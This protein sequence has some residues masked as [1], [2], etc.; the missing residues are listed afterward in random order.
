VSK[1][2]LYQS[3]ELLELPQLVQGRP[4]YF[5][6]LYMHVYGRKLMMNICMLGSIKCNTFLQVTTTF[7]IPVVQTHF[8]NDATCLVFTSSILQAILIAS[9]TSNLQ[10]ASFQGCS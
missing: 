9:T 7:L 3:R 10:L 6:L 4:A 1:S 5:D 2:G 8:Q